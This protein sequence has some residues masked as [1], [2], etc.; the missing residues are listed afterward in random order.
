MSTHISIHNVY[1]I[2][3]DRETPAYHNANCVVFK[4]HSKSMYTE[5]ESE[6][7]LT[8][9]DLPTDL[10]DDLVALIKRHSKK[11]ETV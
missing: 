9:F 6:T 5:Q 2:T 7:S 10:A 8:I 3:T 4:L 1:K 11:E